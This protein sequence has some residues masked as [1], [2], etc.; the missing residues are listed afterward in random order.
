MV[1]PTRAHRRRPA[2][3]GSVYRTDDGRWRGVV[4][5][6]F[7]DGKRKRKY[8][9]GQTQ[10]EALGKLRQAQRDA[11]AGVVSDDRMTVGRFLARWSTVNLPG[12]VS[13][14]TLDDYTHTIR[15]HLGPALGH[16]RLA[17]L[18]V[19]DVDK[20]WAAKRDAGYKPNT[21]R[22]MRA[23]LRRALAQAERE[24]LV[25]RNVAA[26][27]QPAR[28]GQP[29]SRASASTGPRFIERSQGLLVRSGLSY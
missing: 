24:G 8:V 16:K 3:D 18:T 25:T 7:V 19:G 28:L 29:N 10:A 9:S 13:G 14:T 2:G 4:D 21:V 23:V 12:Q 27:S 5:L 26:L 15:L 6:G 11:D 22:I 1:G 20:L 17:G